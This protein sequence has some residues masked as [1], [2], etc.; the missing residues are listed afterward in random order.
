MGE[1]KEYGGQWSEAVNEQ[2]AHKNKKRITGR[3]EG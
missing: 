1:C 3:K 2:E